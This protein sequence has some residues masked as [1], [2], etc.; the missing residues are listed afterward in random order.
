MEKRVSTV[1]SRHDH[2]AAVTVTESRKVMSDSP[3]GPAAE[4][5]PSTPR[6]LDRLRYWAEYL[7]PFVQ[8]ATPP[9]M[10]ILSLIQI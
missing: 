9:A 1:G 7:H 3:I 10:L 6:W 4:P 5:D 8:I 2:P